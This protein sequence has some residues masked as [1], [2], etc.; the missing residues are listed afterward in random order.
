MT[1]LDPSPSRSPVRMVDVV[2]ELQAI[3][4]AADTA[5]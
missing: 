3:A 4:V 1:D 5:T 2:R